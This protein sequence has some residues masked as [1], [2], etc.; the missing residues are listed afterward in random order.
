[1]HPQAQTTKIDTEGKDTLQ[2]K[3]SYFKPA[4]SHT[5][6]SRKYQSSKK[7]KKDPA[8]YTSFKITQKEKKKE[9]AKAKRPT[10]A[11]FPQI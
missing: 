5:A 1:M 8:I 6:V 4:D 7:A 10:N 3:Y 2:A 9:K 11:F